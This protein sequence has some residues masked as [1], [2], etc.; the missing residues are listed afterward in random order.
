MFVGAIA[1]RAITN[2]F[3][4]RDC[5]EQG[6]IHVVHSWEAMLMHFRMKALASHNESINFCIPR[7]SYKAKFALLSVITGVWKPSEQREKILE[8]IILK[9]VNYLL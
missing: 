2:H 5:I 7:F 1:P 3:T 4:D 6:M 8:G 9:N